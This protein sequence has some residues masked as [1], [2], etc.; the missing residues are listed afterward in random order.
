MHTNTVS[1]I[2]SEKTLVVLQFFF[3]FL[4]AHLRCP[5]TFRRLVSAFNKTF[6]DMRHFFSG[7]FLMRMIDGFVPPV[8]FISGLDI[9]EKLRKR[10]L[11]QNKKK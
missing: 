1:A 9:G 10:P 5:Q 4:Y 6:E 3:K 2:F 8:G 11:K 7:K